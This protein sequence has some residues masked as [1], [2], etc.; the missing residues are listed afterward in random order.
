[1]GKSDLSGEIRLGNMLIFS[2][3]FHFLAFSLLLSLPGLPSQPR[4]SPFPQYTSIKLVSLKNLP[5]SKSTNKTVLVKKVKKGPMAK[6][7]MLI[8]KKLVV[9]KPEVAKIVVPKKSAAPPKNATIPEKSASK[10]KK[11]Q[12]L[13]NQQEEK[14]LQQAIGNIREN[15]GKG[16]KAKTPGLIGTGTSEIPEMVVYTSIVIDRIMQA[17]FLPPGLKQEALS[18]N[19]LTI[20][21]IRIDRDGRVS[22][23]GIERNSGNSL[24]DNYA[25][26]AIK[27]IQPESFPPLPEVFRNPYVDLGIRF[28]PSEIN[29]S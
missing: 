22:L 26:A 19:F 15:I 2:C 13:S 10:E 17:W 8:Q 6:K 14:H 9:K 4:I 3:L 27:K 11:Q 1:M 24:Y 20:I 16:V 21:D 23:Q 28:H 18:Q 25:L 7:P 5:G 29:N 12:G